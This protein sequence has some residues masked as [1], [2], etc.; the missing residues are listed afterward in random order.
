MRLGPDGHAAGDGAGGVIDITAIP[1]R[2]RALAGELDSINREISRC[3]PA[4]FQRYGAMQEA[5][6][7]TGAM[8]QDLNRAAN[9]VER[10]IR[11]A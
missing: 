4:E 9:A 1:A 2:L 5:F 8:C 6:D 11:E 10:A 3:L 7:R